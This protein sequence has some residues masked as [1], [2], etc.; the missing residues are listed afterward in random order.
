VRSGDIRGRR[1]RWRNLAKIQR[2]DSGRMTG[3]RKASLVAVAAVP[4]VVLLA[5]IWVVQLS[6]VTVPT[7]V[8]DRPALPSCGEETGTQAGS[9]NPEARQC[10]WDAY[11]A[12]RPAELISTRPT[13]EGDP[14]TSIYRILAAGSVEVFVDYRR[15]RFSKGGWS[16]LLCSGLRRLEGSPWQDDFGPGLGDGDCVVTRLG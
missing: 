10:F 9:L 15:D 6:P 14:V 12:K 11:L 13:V 7:V 3:R 16:R 5:A 1:G 4:L 2:V 8:R